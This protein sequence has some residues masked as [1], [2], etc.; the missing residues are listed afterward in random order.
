MIITCCLFYNAKILVSL[1]QVLQREDSLLS[2]KQ[3]NVLH[4]VKFITLKLLYIRIKSFFVT[5]L[6][7]SHTL[8]F[9]N[10]K[11]LQ[12]IWPIIGAG[13]SFSY[14]V[15]LL[16]ALIG[17]KYAK[18]ILD[19]KVNSLLSLELPMRHTSYLRKTAELA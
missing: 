17:R 18:N 1:F 19:L 10:G 6:N 7:N 3:H 12:I 8:S 11:F 15:P 2:H 5:Y 13:F 9:I 14:S 16:C 4:H